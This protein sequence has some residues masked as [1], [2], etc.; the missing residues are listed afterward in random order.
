MDWAVSANAPA[1]TSRPLETIEEEGPATSTAGI[2]AEPA[3][4]IT[5][6]A[7]AMSKSCGRQPENFLTKCL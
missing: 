3:P 2:E 6:A 5:T 7:V 4:S 1:P